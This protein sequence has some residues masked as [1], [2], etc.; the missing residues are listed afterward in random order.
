MQQDAILIGVAAFLVLVVG[1]LLFGLRGITRFRGSSVG[2]LRPVHTWNWN[3]T[4]TSALFYALAF[5]LI[6]LIQELF[7]VIP[8]ALTPGL[9]PILFHNNHTWSGENPLASLF[10]GT[11][12]LAILCTGVIC[13][14]LL[15]L[16][17]AC[18][19]GVRL[20]LIWMVYNGFLQ[21]LPQVVI[22]SV[23][24]KND[25]GMAMCVFRSIVTGHSDLT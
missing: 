4:V 6:F 7:L 9:R 22:G 3:L 20:L 2:A 24:P 19:A 25:V 23:E 5:N 10:Q 8:K 21:S 13:A 15:K 14:L 11:G 17:P 1:P 18:S 16:C 12:A